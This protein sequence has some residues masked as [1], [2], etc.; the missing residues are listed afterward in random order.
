MAMSSARVMG[1]CTVLGQAVGVAAYLAKKYGVSPREVGTYIKELQQ[2]LLTIDCYLPN[3]KRISGK[4][5][6][7]TKLV[8]CDSEILKNGLD[9]NV[10]ETENRVFIE[11]GKQVWYEFEKPK[12]VAFVKLVFDSDLWR[13][14]FDMHESEKH[15]AMR[16]IHLDNSPIMHLPKTLVK[17]FVLEITHPNGQRS[18]LYQTG[19]N[20]KRSILIPVEQEITKIS[21]TVF[22]NW[23]GTKESGVF[24]FE[25]YDGTEHE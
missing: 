25:L 1:T 7:E 14:T 9:R 3:V 4:A 12:K 5:S 15:H 11:H 10:D 13:K 22:E 19:E 24:T 8:G 16:A 20:I 23:G 18:V 6:T 2:T 17:K 21:L